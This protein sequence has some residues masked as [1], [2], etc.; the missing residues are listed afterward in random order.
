MANGFMIDRTKEGL[1]KATVTSIEWERVYLVLNGFLEKCENYDERLA[2]YTPPEDEEANEILKEGEEGEAEGGSEI[3]S[4]EEG[5]SQDP[6]EGDQ[7]DS[8]AES[9]AES[10]EDPDPDSSEAGL[11]ENAGELNEPAE[12][13]KGLAFYMLTA[14]Y[15]LNAIMESEV[16][17]DGSFTLKVNI[18]NPGYCKCLPS[19]VYSVFVCEGEYIVAHAEVTDELA[20]KIDTYSRVLIHGDGWKAYCTDFSIEN[21]D[22]GLFLNIRTMDVARKG[23]PMIHPKKKKPKPS[24]VRRAVNK[25]KRIRNKKRTKKLRTRNREYYKQHAAE[26]FRAVENGGK[27]GILFLTQQ[28]EEIRNNLEAVRNRLIERGLDQEFNIDTFAQPAAFVP[29]AELHDYEFSIIKKLA[30]ADYVM[31]DDHCPI[32]DWLGLNSNTVVVQLWHAGAGYKAVGYSRWGHP[33]TPGAQSAHRKYT[34]GITPSSKIAYF[35]SEQFGINEE[36]ILPTGM[37]RMD[38]YLDPEHRKQAEEGLYELYPALR[39]RKV[40]LFAPTYRGWGKKTANYPF[41]KVDFG[42]LYDYCGDDKFIVFKMH[43]WVQDPV[44]I[45]EEY[46]DRMADLSDYPDINDIFYI[47]DLLI[48]D[49]SSGVFEYSLMRKPALFYA[50]D[51]HQFEY[52][53][54]FHRDYRSNT[55]GKIVSTFDELMEALE[56]EDFEFEKIDA[57][58]EHHFDHVDTGSSDRVIDWILLGQMP[59]EITEKIEKRRKEVKLLQQLNFSDLKE[60]PKPEPEP[61][62]QESQPEGLP[63]APVQQTQAA[64]Q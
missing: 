28:N 56:K 57:Y 60:K 44:P 2:D 11:E 47:T 64:G 33:K 6:G 15:V 18:T 31:L 48:S 53:R 61:E 25:F 22:A 21:N 45:P 63:E 32:L 24:L 26:H 4:G 55:P 17:A 27:K 46:L 1:L 20:S 3:A 62:A 5:V 38:K 39:E 43:P 40:L 35:F 52:S 59:E 30:E 23:I 54:G 49:Y 34:Y 19:A 10:A 8:D 7:E 58:I 13:P 41:E 12:L 36:Q 50:F 29:K 9:S 14:H 51:E 16:R 37:P 42:R